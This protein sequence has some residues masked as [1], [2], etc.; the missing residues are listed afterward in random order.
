MD[1]AQFVKTAPAY[2]AMAIMLFFR[3]SG[4]QPADG[5]TIE[6]SLSEHNDDSS[7]PD[8]LYYFLEKPLIFDR[9]MGWL[10]D[11]DIIEAVHDE[12]GPSIFLPTSRFDPMISQ[13]ER[14]P[15]LPFQKFRTLRYSE[16][17]LRSALRKVNETYDDLQITRSDFENPDAEWQPIPLER[18]APELQTAI[19]KLDKTIEQVR[20]DNGYSATVPEERALVLES[21]ATASRI[22]KEATSISA[23]FLKRYAFE[24]LQMLI[25]RFGPA[26]I[27]IAATGARDALVEFVK[28]HGA[29]LLDW[30][31]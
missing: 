12:F 20:G 1:R 22:L 17:W 2:Y 3:N 31:F 19:A 29:K 16:S 5:D 9:A 10:I 6:R 7:D 21:L 13:L 25:R 15:N 8:D 28:Q 24:P 18:D 4:Q 26:A 27:G 14:D 30:L 23:P 11:E